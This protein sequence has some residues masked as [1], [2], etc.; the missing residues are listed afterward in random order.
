VT[1]CFSAENQQPSGRNDSD[2]CDRHHSL[3]QDQVRAWGR[4][5]NDGFRRRHGGRTVPPGILIVDGDDV[6]AKLFPEQ[7]DRPTFLEEIIQAIKDGKIVFMTNGLNIGNSPGT[8][9]DLAPGRA[10]DHLRGYL[11]GRPVEP[12][13]VFKSKEM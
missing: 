5:S 12:W 6:R 8:V 7:E 3:R 11:K 13:T 9:Q 4:G 1:S 10:Y 2:R